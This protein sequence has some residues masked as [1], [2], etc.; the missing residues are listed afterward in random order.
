MELGARM[1][2]WK[3]PPQPFSTD[4]SL[5]QSEG[6]PQLTSE[7]RWPAEVR[8]YGDILFVIY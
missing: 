8:T 7:K 2:S 1:G 3:G 4:F 5:K 6:S